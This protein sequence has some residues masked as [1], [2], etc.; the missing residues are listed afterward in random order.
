MEVVLV[1]P[2][3]TSGR[4]DVIQPYGHLV[5]PTRGETLIR[6]LPD[7]ADHCSQNVLT[8]W[9]LKEEAGRGCFCR[10][11]FSSKDFLTMDDFGGPEEG[12]EGL[13]CIGYKDNA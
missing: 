7:P 10:P 1:P 9:F 3:G 8:W 6:S 5:T 13:K 4:E 2:A 11:R 12:E